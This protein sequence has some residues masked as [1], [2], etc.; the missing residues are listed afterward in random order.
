[1]STPILHEVTSVPVITPED[2]ERSRIARYFQRIL[3]STLAVVELR[4]KDRILF[5]DAF[6]LRTL[7]NVEPT[8]LPLKFSK[9]TESILSE[10]IDSLL[11]IT[12]PEVGD[13]EVT[14]AH[15]TSTL[16]GPDSAGNWKVFNPPDFDFV[17]R[18]PVLPE[19]SPSGVGSYLATALTI[20][21]DSVDL[22]EDD[23]LIRPDRLVHGETEFPLDLA[24][25]FT[26]RDL[27]ARNNGPEGTGTRHPLHSISATEPVIVTLARHWGL[28]AAILRINS[29]DSFEVPGI[30]G[31]RLRRLT[32]WVVKSGCHPS[33]VYE[34]LA[35]ICNVSCKF[36]YLFGNPSDLSV[37]RGTAVTKTE[38]E[39]RLR[40]YDPSQNRALF[41]AQWEINEFLVDPKIHE[42]L[43]KLRKLSDEP[44]YFI[45][46]GNPLNARTIDLLDQVQP[47]HLIVSVNTFDQGLRG[48]VMKEGK[49]RTETAL[50]ALEELVRREIPFGISLAAFPDFS[51]EDMTRTIR[52]AASIP[53]AFV[54]INLPGFTRYLPYPKPIDTLAHWNRVTD[55][56]ADLRK[57]I[58]IPLIVIPSAFEE[59]RFEDPL[60]PRILGCIAGSPA[61]AAGLQ[62]GDVILSINNFEV[63]TRADIHSLLLLMNREV[64][65]KVRRDDRVFEC[66]LQANGPSQYPY[67]G[68]V[69]CK[70]VFPQGVVASPALS[71]RAVDQVRDYVTSF[72][73]AR[74]WIITSP[75][76][77]STAKALIQKGAPELLPQVR[78]VVA[79][80]E[81]LGGNIMVMDMCTVSDIAS[82][83]QKQ[84]ATD[85]A[86]DLILLSD[87]GFNERGR[88]LEGRH[89][90]DLERW[91]GIPVRLLSCAR[92]SY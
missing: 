22:L 59:S 20:V 9:Q 90:G 63:Q 37:A 30:S 48:E 36:C 56:I 39:T 78:F 47:V 55:L 68:P 73:A 8:A 45:T 15:W 25:P 54:R 41:Q 33:E 75:I 11:E 88:D 71:L 42:V 92:F 7:W 12:I 67:C 18:Y 66:T 46:N 80:N 4:S 89:W 74:C 79:R 51:F 61:E 72:S 17:F 91:C 76:M 62:A 60:A 38:I 53:A 50:S 21:L 31:F 16:A 70:Y 5:P 6:L 81:F 13:R 26:R 32:D 77:E 14:E 52:V 27:G 86:P 35:R 87:S 69:I 84:M 28:L 2:E 57:E 29:T 44:F 85:R 10:H 43:P 58:P 49:R 24:S 19:V 23:S 34:H 3:E 82:A 40:Y 64:R 65:L 83:I 1:M